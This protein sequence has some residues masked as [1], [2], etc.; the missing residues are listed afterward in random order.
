MKTAALI[1]LTWA[2]VLLVT[3]GM[4]D[5]ETYEVPQDFKDV[6]M[7]LRKASYGDTV[8]IHPGKYKVQERVRSGVV[9]ISA[10]G[11]DSTILWNNR[12][13]IL[14]LNDCDMATV[15]SGLTLDGMACNVCVVCTTGAPVIENN[16]IWH[17]WDGISLYK[18]N[19]TIK[20]NTI[21]GCNRGL[22]IDESDPEVIDN[23]LINNGD[24]ISLISS[25]PVIARCTLESNGRAILI[26]GHS[27][28]TIGGSL[29]A[30]NL[31]IDNGYSV[32]NNG[33]RIEG[34]QF[35]D[36]PEVAVA[37][38]NYWGTLCPDRGKMRGAVVF[39][40][41]TDAKRESTYENCPQGTEEKSEGTGSEGAGTR[42][43]R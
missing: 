27:Y 3:L 19:A 13:H 7:A 34:T 18:C 24:G 36:E 25:A 35:T 16:V 6:R 41:W 8:L 23:T 37:T 10:E 28:P 14:E 43:T 11:P 12:W 21:R 15:I 30:A 4:I 42:K 39:K 26:Q 17:S 22:Y 5:A 38:Y 20:N 1:M 9:V 2:G 31:L 40:P 32:Y 29:D 33:L